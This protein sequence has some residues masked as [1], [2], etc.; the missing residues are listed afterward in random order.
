MNY[1]TL[2]IFIT[3]SPGGSIPPPARL[4]GNLELE[5]SSQTRW[6]WRYQTAQGI[7]RLILLNL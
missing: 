2:S 5:H 6:E 3:L 4:S 7:S 1:L